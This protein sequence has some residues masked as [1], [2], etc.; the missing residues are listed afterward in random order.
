MNSFGRFKYSP[1]NFNADLMIFGAGETARLALRYFRA[2]SPFNLRGLVVDDE[3]MEDSPHVVDGFQVMRFSELERHGSRKTLIFVAIAA[4]NLSEYRLLAMERLK[5]SGFSLTNYISS[6][7]FVDDDVSLGENVMVLE[8]N[9]LQS[10]VRIGD[11]TIIWSGNH[12]G[13]QTSIGRGNFVSSH[14]CIGGRVAI[15]NQNYFG[16]NSTV[17]DTVRIDDYCVIGA[18]TYVSKDISNSGI[19]VGTPAKLLEGRDPR[20]AIN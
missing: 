13:H 18:N 9:T 10:E 5:N 15:G 20:S 12:I 17:R 3:K 2:D 1:S 7:A 6:R 8:N 16:M 11:G 14:V 19:Y 4:K